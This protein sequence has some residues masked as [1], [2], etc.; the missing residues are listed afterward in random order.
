MIYELD[1]KLNGQRYFITSDSKDDLITA[2]YQKGHTGE[3]DGEV[4]VMLTDIV[5][6]MYGDDPPGL[7][8][9]TEG[10]VKAPASAG[11]V[12]PIITIVCCKCGKKHPNNIT[13]KESDLENMGY[14]AHY[15]LCPKCEKG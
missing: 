3:I 14:Y 6:A 11:K 12:D 10:I 13:I 15:Y 7:F 5:E 2:I 8:S 1:V 9:W 4:A